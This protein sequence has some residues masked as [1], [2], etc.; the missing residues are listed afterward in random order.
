MSRVDGREGLTSWARIRGWW[1]TRAFVSFVASYEYS[2]GPGRILHQVSGRYHGEL[3][4]APVISYK[5][6][7]LPLYLEKDVSLDVDILIR[8][9]RYFFLSFDGL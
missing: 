8:R 3:A 7:N 4:Q 1:Y 6:M 2:V 5:P 9:H